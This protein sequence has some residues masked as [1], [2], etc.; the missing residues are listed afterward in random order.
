MY[1]FCGTAGPG[2]ERPTEGSSIRF[3][4]PKDL[5]SIK[6]VYELATTWQ[7]YKMSDLPIGKK[8]YRGN[9]L[10][11]SNITFTLRIIKGYKVRL[12]E[13]LKKGRKH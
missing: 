11:R 13:N 3:G 8:M 4:F 1:G 5:K 9:R 10:G 2:G 12:F 6:V 7:Y